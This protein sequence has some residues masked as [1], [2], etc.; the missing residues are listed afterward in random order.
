MVHAY[1]HAD[2]H[3]CIHTYIHTL[4]PYSPLL[5]ARGRLRNRQGS[6]H[7]CVCVYVCI[8]VY[9]H[10]PPY[11]RSSTHTAGWGTDRV[12]RLLRERTV[13]DWNWLSKSDV[14]GWLSVNVACYSLLDQSASSQ[15][16]QILVSKVLTATLTNDP[17]VLLLSSL[18]SFLS[19]IL[20][21]QVL[22][23]WRI[24]QRCLSCQPC[25]SWL[26][27]CTV[28]AR[29]FSHIFSEFWILARLSVRLDTLSAPRYSH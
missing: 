12:Q 26:L 16:A 6:Y 22:W 3:T 23:F 13:A 11:P 15:F 8:C 21:S 5:N 14:A 4:P 2:I 17:K 10:L 27:L 18:K 7:V 1:I 24:A 19:Q 25:S 20:V 9:D 28:R 29:I